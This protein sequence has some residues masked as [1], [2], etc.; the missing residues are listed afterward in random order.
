MTSITVEEVLAQVHA[1]LQPCDIRS[2]Q[3][4]IS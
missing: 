3:L 4:L 2:R 1:L